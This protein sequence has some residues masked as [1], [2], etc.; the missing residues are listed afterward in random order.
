MQETITAQ[1]RLM[2]EGYMLNRFKKVSRQMGYKAATAGEHKKW[3]KAARAKL[4]ALTGFDSMIK[5]AAKPVVTES[6]KKEGYTRHRMEIQTEPG[7]VMSFYA[8]VPDGKGPFP[9]VIC[10]HGHASGGKYSPAGITEIPVIAKQIKEYNYDYGVKFAQAGAIALCPDARGFGERQER[11]NN[12]WSKGDMLTQSCQMI[13]QMAYPLGQT[14]TGMWAWDLLALARYSQTRKDVIK[15][16]LA[17]VGLSGGGLQ[18]LWATA[19]DG[20][21][22]IKVAV[23]SGYFYGYR[24]SLLIKHGNCSCN[25]VPHLYENVDMGD[26]AAL[27]A[28]RPLLIETGDED[29]LNGV[30][31]V[32]NVLDQLKITRKAYKTLGAD[33]NLVHD[34]FPGGHKWHGEIA[35]PWVMQCLEN[36]DKK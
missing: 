27:I 8:L 19:L 35:V 25:Y 6:V 9:V 36:L 7:V 11:I 31:K 32:K 10:A 13:N 18:T 4:M 34:I 3:A 21:E 24:E 2:V 1:P 28:P 14:V 16:K 17:C 23:V 22:L 29:P 5:T 33:E 30:S 15:G 20:E 26:V 12:L